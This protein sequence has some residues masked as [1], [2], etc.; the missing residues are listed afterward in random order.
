MEWAHAPFAGRLT[1]QLTLRGGVPRIPH[2]PIFAAALAILGA[3]PFHVPAFTEFDLRPGA[4][5]SGGDVACPPLGI[6]DPELVKDDVIFARTVLVKLVVACFMVIDDDRQFR[7]CFVKI[8]SSSRIPRQNFANEQVTGKREARKLL[9]EKNFPANA[10]H[11]RIS[12]SPG[13]QNRQNL[14]GF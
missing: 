7:S 13:G 5:F 10:V 4:K 9:P 11:V 6:I 2:Q 8:S 1:G 12:T 14:S 3:A